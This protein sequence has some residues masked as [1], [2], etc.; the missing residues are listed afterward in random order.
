MINLCLKNIKATAAF[1]D[2]WDF[3]S[4]LFEVLIKIETT[5]KRRGAFCGKPEG[6]LQGLTVVCTAQRTAKHDSAFLHINTTDIPYRRGSENHEMVW[7][8]R[9]IEKTFCS[10]PAMAVT[11]STVPDCSKSCPAWHWAGSRGFKHLFPCW[12][13]WKLSMSYAHH[14]CSTA[15]A[16][17]AQSL[18]FLEFV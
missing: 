14:V 17:K 4:P 11:P 13:Q 18:F 2:V 15:G 8:G 5:T 3:S 1:W 10:T 12:A 16:H 9:D 6:E 7:V